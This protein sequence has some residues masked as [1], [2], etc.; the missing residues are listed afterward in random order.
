M[1]SLFSLYK[2][3]L[4]MRAIAILLILL[5]FVGGQTSFV[6]AENFF[7]D[8]DEDKIS[9]DELKLNKIA[10]SD[11]EEYIKIEEISKEEF[12]KL[13]FG[14]KIAAI[15]LTENDYILIRTEE[16]TYHML[17]FAPDLIGA[18]ELTGLLEEGSNLKAAEDPPGQPITTSHLFTIYFMLV[19]I[20]VFTFSI[21][22]IKRRYK[23]M[24]KGLIPGGRQKE[25]EKEDPSENTQKITFDH[26][27][28][29]DELKPDLMRLV[30]ALKN[31][32][33]Y[34][35]LGARP[36]KGLILYG[37][38]GTG[39]TLIAKA[40]SGEA[41]VP[42]FAASGSDFMEKYV[43]VGASR[44]RE[45]FNK[46]RKEAPSIVFIDEI[47]AIGGGRGD[48]NNSEKDQT[49]NALL[50]ELD[51]F[52]PSEGVLT[53]C[54]TNRLDMLDPALTR[55][56]RFDLKVAVNLPDKKARYQILRL[57]SA[58]KV[59]SKEV[60]IHELV[61]KTNGFS[62]AELEN[63]LN[64]AALIAAGKD[65]ECITNEDVEDAFYKIL[66]NG[67]KKERVEGDKHVRL[68]AYHEAGHT[69]AAKLISNDSVSAVTIM[70]STSG[71]GGVTFRSQED[72]SLRSKKELRD[73]IKVMYAGRAAEELYLGDADDITTG[74][75][76]DI[77]QATQIIKEY[78][79]I[80]GMGNNGMIDLTQLTNQFNI[81]EEASGLAI[82]L[83]QETKEFLE[84]HKEKLDR[85]A[86]A[87]MEKET[88]NEAE[89]DAILNL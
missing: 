50:T 37:P 44:I 14:M 87:L 70:Q 56:G 28:G 12:Y 10:I 67:Y 46:A 45:L 21:L 9:Y 69:L 31:P 20:T 82:S 33:K 39:K 6:C 11:L 47:D 18:L 85:L 4:Y 60:D 38:P 1:F 78:I 36:T 26:V 41:G 55:P 75:S 40:I 64:E 79:G 51:G 19:V 34:K 84:A 81:I 35:R 17:P 43:G 23:A 29:I 27:Q 72:T 49:I 57:H 66:M 7:F 30:D 73:L 15:A 16:N 24:E 48:S 59:L 74:A 62:G 63:L 54:A 3:S 13:N 68:I 52:L 42:F 89:I 25:K 80:Y 2:N 65:R 71:A 86:Q 88:L 53:I 76:Q 77:K 61:K 58:N 8:D 5:V 32:E 22:A 83:Y